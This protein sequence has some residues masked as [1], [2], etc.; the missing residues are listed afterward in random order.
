[1]GRI[2]TPH[3]LQDSSNI[4]YIYIGTGS[5]MAPGTYFS[6][7]IDDVRIYNRVVIP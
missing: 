5:A 4:V 2:F 6:G 1:M 3:G 7:L